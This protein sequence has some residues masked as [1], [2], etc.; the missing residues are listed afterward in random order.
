MVRRGS[1]IASF[2]HATIDGSAPKAS[3][4]GDEVGCPV[5]EREEQAGRV[6]FRL[7]A[8]A[9]APP[10][11]G[12][13]SSN[14]LMSKRERSASGRARS[15]HGISSSH[16]GLFEK[17]LVGRARRRQDALPEGA[18]VSQRTPWC[19]VFLGLKSGGCV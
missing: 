8:S 15:I 9:S 1:D 17:L 6:C 13:A 19:V 2:S 14:S 18:G 3:E 12:R 16:R 11:L 4:S 5:C 10:S 7:P